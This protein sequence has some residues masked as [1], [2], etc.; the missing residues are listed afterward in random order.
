MRSLVV[1]VVHEVIDALTQFVHSFRKIQVDVLLFDCA[2]ESFYPYI[3]P[4]A[5]ASVHADPDS[6]AI[7]QIQPGLCGELATLI[8]IDDYGCPISLYTFFQ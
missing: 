6:V 1:I 2:P 4:A 5:S 3:V 8:G 7:K